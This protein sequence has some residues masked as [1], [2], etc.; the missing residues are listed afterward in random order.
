MCL[1]YHS[2][3]FEAMNFLITQA[4]RQV[5][6]VMDLAGVKKI[7]IVVRVYVVFRKKHI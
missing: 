6:E 3:L 2:L 7:C 1:L 5:G 4:I